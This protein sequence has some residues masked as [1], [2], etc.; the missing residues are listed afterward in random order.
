VVNG[1]VTGR[2]IVVGAFRRGMKTPAFPVSLD[3]M[4]SK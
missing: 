1:S 4:V 3:T 2:R